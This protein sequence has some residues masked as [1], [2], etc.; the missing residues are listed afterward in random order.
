LARGARL[1]VNRQADG[2]FDMRRSFRTA[3][4]SLGLAL[5]A[6]GLAAAQTDADRN[7]GSGGAGSGASGNSGAVNNAPARTSTADNRDDRGFPYGLLGLLGLAGLIPLFTRRNN[8]ERYDNFG[9]PVTTN[10][11]R[12]AHA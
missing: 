8:H 9:R 10:T 11:A 4:L 12:G 6:T 5:G 2:V 7:N 1:F 3:I